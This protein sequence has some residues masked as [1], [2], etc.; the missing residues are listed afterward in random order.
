MFYCFINGQRSLSA[1]P[2]PFHHFSLILRG[3]RVLGKARLQHV[4]RRT[5][6]ASSQL[7]DTLNCGKQVTRS[8]L[9]MP[10]FIR[11]KNPLPS[12]V[13]FLGG[14][15]ARHVTGPR[16]CRAKC[17]NVKGCLLYQKKHMLSLYSSVGINISAPRGINSGILK[18]Q[19]AEGTHMPK[20]WSKIPGLVSGSLETAA[21]ANLAFFVI[22]ASAGGEI[23]C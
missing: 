18:I 14:L 7:R 23:L 2:P 17:C 3:R 6:P 22:F 15:A 16:R 4:G 8:C 20:S 5:P 10:H 13:S 12:P 1:R 19:G 21:C 11:L 9:V